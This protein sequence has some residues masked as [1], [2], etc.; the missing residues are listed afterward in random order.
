MC[1]HT[2]IHIH[3]WTIKPHWLDLVPFVLTITS[4]H[5]FYQSAKIRDFFFFWGGKQCKWCKHGCRSNQQTLLHMVSGSMDQESKKLQWE[6]KRLKHCFLSLL[7]F[8]NQVPLLLDCLCF[9][10]SSNTSKVYLNDYISLLQ[11][12]ANMQFQGL[13]LYSTPYSLACITLLVIIVW[14]L[15]N[16]APD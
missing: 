5:R 1:T 4:C 3:I 9:T 12:E 7:V 13:S 14:K 2:L 6:I 15:L 8:T 11:L 10:V 16:A